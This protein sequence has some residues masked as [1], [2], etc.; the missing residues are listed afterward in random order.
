MSAAC[1]AAALAAILLAAWA[2]QAQAQGPSPFTPPATNP[3]RGDGMWIWYVS[4]AR[5]AT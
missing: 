5:A 1:C 2:P 3:L 4:S